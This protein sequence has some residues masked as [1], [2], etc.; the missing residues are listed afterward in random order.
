[1][2]KKFRI[3]LLHLVQSPAFQSKRH[4]WLG[5]SP[6]TESTYL[7]YNSQKY[8]FQP[9]SVCGSSCARS[10]L[11]TFSTLH[12]GSFIQFPQSRLL[13]S[14]YLVATVH[15]SEDCYS[16]KSLFLQKGKLHLPVK[17][18]SCSKL[19]IISFSYPNLEFSEVM[20]GGNGEGCKNR[21]RMSFFCICQHLEEK[22]K[23]LILYSNAKKKNELVSSGPPLI[24][25][26]IICWRGEGNGRKISACSALELISSVFI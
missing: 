5:K 24:C 25:V 23:K 19:C 6:R 11:H 1:M 18:A 15:H 26:L 10:V 9:S 16:L 2:Q 12:P 7:N 14:K 20:I 21:D 22:P 8:H 13:L 3:F 4:A 17:M